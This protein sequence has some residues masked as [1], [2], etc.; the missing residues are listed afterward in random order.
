MPD[1]TVPC[2]KRLTRIGRWREELRIRDTYGQ[3][4]LASKIWLAYTN[5]VG[6]KCPEVS[7]MLDKAIALGRRALGNLHG[8]P[9]SANYY[10]R[11]KLTH[12]DRMVRE[13]IAR[14][15]RGERPFMRMRQA[16]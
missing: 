6:C 4:L 2:P 1:I 13:S 9:C 3:S 8:D 15:R 14:E 11:R 12:G 7:E 10:E 5:A 16:G